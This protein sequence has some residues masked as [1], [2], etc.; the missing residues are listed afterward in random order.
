MFYTTHSHIF[1]W[2]VA[3][4]L[5]AV[6]V[7]LFKKGLDK[8]FKIVHMALRLFYLLILITGGILF[9]QFAS[10]D[11]MLYGLKFVSG[12]AVIAFSE[13]TLVRMKKNKSL[14]GV[15]AGLIVSALVTFY[16]GFSLPI[17]FNFLP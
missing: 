3:V 15:T 17:G 8:Q 7:I 9:V 2:A 4:I 10:I 13:I 1:T 11:H 16:L 5:F 12:L 6:A 14:G